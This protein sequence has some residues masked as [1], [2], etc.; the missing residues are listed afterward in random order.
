MA[1]VT[2]SANSLADLLSAVRS[3]C[4]ANGWTLSGEVLHRGSSYFRLWQL[5]TE[6]WIQGG[7]GIDGSNNLTGASPK[8]SRMS[9]VGAAI[10]FPLTYDIH[11]YDSP[12]EVYVV[13]NYS[14]DWYQW[15]MFGR[16]DVPGLPGTGNWFAATRW[17]DSGTDN[18]IYCSPSGGSTNV[19]LRGCPA[20]WAQSVS[21]NDGGI[22][23][24]IHHNVDGRG[25]G[26]TTTSTDFCRSFGAIDTLLGKLPNAF[27]NET[28]LLPFQVWVPRTSGGTV[29]LVADMKNLRHCR[30]D[31]HLP[32]EIISIASDRWMIYPWLRRDTTDRNGPGLGTHSG[33]T[34]FAVRYTGP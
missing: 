24:H 26:V 20:F 16:S 30:N 34:A 1:Y 27:N 2:G 29:S 17:Q 5:T 13:I 3:A 15:V 23:S 9:T 14:T 8:A 4:T 18:R 28:V 19:T 11:I 21:V 10:T 22:N 7:T 6:F 12:D 25:W 33:T 32:R 31:F